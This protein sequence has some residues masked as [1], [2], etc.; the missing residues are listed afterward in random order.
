MKKKKGSYPWVEIASVAVCLVCILNSIF[1]KI[2]Y[3]PLESL[4]R[5]HGR[6]YLF[7]MLDETVVV[8]ILWLP[9]EFDDFLKKTKPPEE[10]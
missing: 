7:I 8:L 2:D 5:R 3:L 4:S 10:I 9:E 6:Y 1:A